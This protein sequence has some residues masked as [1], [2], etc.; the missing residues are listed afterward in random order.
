[1]TLA[2]RYSDGRL[3]RGITRGDGS[4]GE[5]VTLNVLSVRSVPLSI[6]KDKLKK[7]GMPADFEGR[8]EFL[9][10]LAAFRKLNEERARQGLGVLANPRT[11]TARTFSRPTT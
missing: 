2:L 9:M 11:L 10:P 8:G 3:E 5:D 1:M 7:A 6:S 4:V